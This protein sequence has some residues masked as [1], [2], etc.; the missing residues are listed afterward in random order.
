MFARGAVL[1]AAAVSL[2]SA[3][4]PDADK[5]V[6]EIFRSAAVGQLPGAAVAV[7]RDG[8]VAFMK[9]YG[10]A[11]MESRMPNSSKTKFRLASV[12]KSFTAIAVLQLVEAGKL[13]LHDPLSK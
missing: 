13:K 6:D 10:L 5:R 8:E 2:C 9:A 12:T 4:F 3:A 7:V 1:L 11:D